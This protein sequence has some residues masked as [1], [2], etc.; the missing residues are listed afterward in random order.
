MLRR[1]FHDRV[2]AAIEIKNWKAA[3]SAIEEGINLNP[4]SIFLRR[5][6]I[7]TSSAQSKPGP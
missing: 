3:L 6:F 1:L 4:D 5:N 7:G 2:S